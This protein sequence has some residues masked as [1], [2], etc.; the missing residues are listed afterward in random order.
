MMTS[1]VRQYAYGQRS[2][3]RKQ[4]VAL[5]E[6]VSLTHRLLGVIFRINSENRLFK[7]QLGSFTIGLFRQTYMLCVSTTENNE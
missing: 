5:H 6:D 7:M 3:H 2:Y 1:T 4:C